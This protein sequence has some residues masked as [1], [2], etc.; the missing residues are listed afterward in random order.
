MWERVCDEGL[1]RRVERMSGRLAIDVGAGVGAGAGDFGVGLE[2]V[3][4]GSESRGVEV[5]R[6]GVRRPSM[7]WW[8]VG[9]GREDR[10]R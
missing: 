8:W 2:I 6:R 4:R 9:W 10:Q 5:V 7:V 3:R 1:E